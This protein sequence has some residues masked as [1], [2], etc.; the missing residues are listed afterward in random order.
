M[1]AGQLD[2]QIAQLLDTSQRTVEHEKRHV[3]GLL[4]R[5]TRFTLIWAVE[6]RRTIREGVQDWASAPASVRKL[7]ETALA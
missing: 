7:I 1:S 4:K 3:A 6:N 2:K 5:E